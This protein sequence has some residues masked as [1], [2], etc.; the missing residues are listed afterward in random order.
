MVESVLHGLDKISLGIE[1]I[2]CACDSP[3]E[4]GS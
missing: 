1:V 3:V 2:R 4:G